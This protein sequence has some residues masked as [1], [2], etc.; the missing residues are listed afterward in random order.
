MNGMPLV[1]P[2][3]AKVS[4]RHSFGWAFAGGISFVD[5]GLI[6]Q[7]LVI[8]D[9]VALLVR[10]K[11]AGNVFFSRSRVFGGE[12]ER[13]KERASDL[14]LFFFFSLPPPPLSK[15]SIRDRMREKEEKKSE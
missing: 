14:F 5:A 13:A 7:D 6:A 1:A 10:E 11:G 9:S 8:E 2:T 4:I 3:V 15:Y 12:S